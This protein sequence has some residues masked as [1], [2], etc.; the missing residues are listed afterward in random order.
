[1]QT[2]AE[3]Q[4]AV[5]ELARWCGWLV[6]HPRPART[7]KGWATAIQGDA[8]YPDLTLVHSVKKRIIIVELKTP[9]GRTSE[10]QRRWLEALE[11]VP[12]VEAFLWRPSDWPAIQTTLKFGPDERPRLR[13]IDAIRRQ[14]DEPS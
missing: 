2:E 9:K 14:L 6:F 3:F 11:A 4:A 5:V 10:P 13:S 1:M 12:G 7:S 8:G